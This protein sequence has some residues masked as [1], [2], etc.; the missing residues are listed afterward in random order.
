MKPYYD[1]GT[2]TLYLGDARK[3]VPA[4]GLT[5]DLVLADPPYQQTGHSW[6]RWPEG[7]LQTAATAGNSLWCFGTIGTFLN[8][9]DE[10]TAAGWKLRH[11]VIG[12]DPDGVPV[13]GEVHVVWEKNT[14]TGFNADTPRRVHEHALHW[15][16]GLWR[17]LHHV[18]P[19]LPHNG[20]DKGTVRRTVHANAFATGGA[21]GDR[22]WVDDGLRALRSV[23]YA[24]NLRGKAVHSTQKPVELLVP[25]VEYACARGGLVLD[26]FAGS[27]SALVAAR[28]CG[29]R[30]IGI[31]ADEAQIE[32]AAKRLSQG[33]LDFEAA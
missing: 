31:E 28:S 2:V 30:A 33:V 13:F 16:R 17:D 32:E 11:D 1:D 23:I 8:H 12:Q 19:R 6:D 25:L 21:L 15:Y 9:R 18:V 3:V 29:R 26:L 14:G 4:L 5:A 24:A 20:P 7:W 10:F 27:G 22:A